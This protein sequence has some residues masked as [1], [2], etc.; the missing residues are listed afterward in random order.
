M[1]ALLKKPVGFPGPLSTPENVGKKNPIHIGEK[2]KGT[3][4]RP[5]PSGDFP[6]STLSLKGQSLWVI[7]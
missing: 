4:P 7:V 3:L 6:R 1:E 2:K 5:S